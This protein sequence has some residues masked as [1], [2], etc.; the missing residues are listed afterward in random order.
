VV[1]GLG[2][3]V[4]DVVVLVVVDVVL[5]VVVVVVASVVVVA[6]SHLQSTVTGK[7]QTPPCDPSGE[8]SPTMLLLT[9]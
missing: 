9:S 5:F 1:V 2:V 4:V 7:Y 8:G 6:G 3:V